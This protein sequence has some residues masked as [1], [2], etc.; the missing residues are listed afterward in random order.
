M[1]KA[2]FFFLLITLVSFSAQA[3]RIFGKDFWFV[4]NNND[5][6]AMTATVTPYKLVIISAYNVSGTVTMPGYP[7]VNM[8]FTVAANSQ[9]V[10]TLNWNP[11]GSGSIYPINPFVVDKKGIHIVTDNDATVYAVS[12]QSSG[13]TADGEVVLPTTLL[14]T[15]YVVASRG[16]AQ[17][18]LAWPAQ[19]T[20]CATQNG[21]VATIKTWYLKGTKQRDTTIVKTLNAG[22][23]YTCEFRRDAAGNLTNLSNQMNTLTGST[24]TSNF[25][26]AVISNN[27]CSRMI[28]CGACDVMMDE[29][30]PVSNW[31]TK[32]VVNQTIKRTLSSCSSFSLTTGDYLEIIGTVGQQ[33]TIRNWSGSTN[34]TIPAI[35]FTPAG[36]TTSVTNYGFLWYDNPKNPSLTSP[37]NYGEANAVIT[38]NQ[39]FAVVQYQKDGYTDN[40][41]YTDPEAT[42]CYPE[43]MWANNYIAGTVTTGGGGSIQDVIFVVDNTGTPAP[44]TKF[45]VDGVAVPSVTCTGTN[46]PP[47][48]NCWQAMA[49]P[50]GSNYMFIRYP[51]TPG[52]AHILSNTGGYNFGFYYATRSNAGSYIVQGGG[53]AAPVL[54]IPIDLIAFEAKLLGNKTNVT[55]TTLS[56]RN[57]EGFVVERSLDGVHFIPISE[58]IPASGNSQVK[59]DYAYVDS[60]PVI[61]ENYYRLK[62]IDLDG[63]VAYAPVRIV[64]YSSDKIFT[65]NS[66]Q[67]NPSSERLKINF[68]SGSK[69]N[70]FYDIYDL[71][72]RRVLSKELNNVQLGTNEIDV[73]I[74]DLENG[75]YYLAL[76][77]NN[78][79]EPIR[80]K[81]V[82][83]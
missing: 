23:T 53:G 26:V 71:S 36:T 35:P 62:E 78:I 40:L 12:A 76:K 52:V 18:G 67:P 38:S 41:L 11:G 83:N 27:Q 10:V 54:T 74:K 70:L 5:D 42:V 73:N 82:K 49:S 63:K 39:P 34:Y 17:S 59:L 37:E 75:L 1:K 55:W 64:N 33:I 61:G 4:F 56:E 47:G 57:T 46:P 65:L 28:D 31:G 7:S 3:Q 48:E 9:T 45:T 8:P 19:F 77:K 21:T 80:I 69:D 16:T 68:N 15:S 20:V 60:E 44:I 14:G 58:K 24:V 2:L 66:F 32:Y 29:L 22:E 30:L 79:E 81:F 13:T 25:P 6:V 43:A 50:A 72:G 51:V